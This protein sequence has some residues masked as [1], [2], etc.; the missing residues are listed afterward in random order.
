MSET[1]TLLPVPMFHDNYLWLWASSSGEVLAVDV[2]DYALLA[3]VLQDRGWRLATVFVTHHHHDHTGGL[4]EIAHRHPGIPIYG[5]TAIAGINRPV[6]GGETLA[7]PGLGDWTVLAT[8]GHTH[9]HVSFYHPEE[10]VLFCGDTLFSGGCGR[11]FDGD[12]ESFFQSLQTICGLPDR[13]RVCCAH[14]Y[15]VANLDFA[16]AVDPGNKLLHEYRTAAETLRMAGIPTLPAMLGLEKAI[17]PFLRTTRP[18]LREILAET[19]PGL[20][21]NPSASETFARLRRFKDS[22]RPPEA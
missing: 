20:G 2:G 11:I 7:L 16:L 17:N 22:W 14:E 5:P 8:P 6:S 21:L 4:P 1:Y 13:T 10:A 9:D 3:K 19:I 12:S 18:D 15:T